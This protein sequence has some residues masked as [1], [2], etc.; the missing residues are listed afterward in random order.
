MEKVT[1]DVLTAKVK[2]DSVFWTSLGR[3]W[4]NET[5]IKIEFNALP[6]PNPNGDVF[7]Y[8]KEKDDVQKSNVKKEER[9][10]V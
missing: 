5:N 9:Q 2:N 7:V 3:A 1:Y 6:T 4:K 10:A 8:L